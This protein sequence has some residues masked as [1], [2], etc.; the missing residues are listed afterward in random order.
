MPPPYCHG[1]TGGV[2]RTLLVLLVMAVTLSANVAGASSPVEAQAKNRVY[3]PNANNRS[4]GTA[5][6][7]VSTRW[8]VRLGAAPL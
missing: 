8:T 1:Y 2:A 3:L 6:T 7:P 4:G 5:P